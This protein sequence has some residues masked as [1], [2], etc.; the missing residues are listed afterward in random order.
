LAVSVSR[1]HLITRI[2]SFPKKL[3][4]RPYPEKNNFFIVCELSNLTESF[5]FLAT[6]G[7]HAY[8]LLSNWCH[9]ILFKN[10]EEKWPIVKHGMIPFYLH[11]FSSCHQQT[12]FY[13][14]QENCRS[15][16]LNSCA[17]ILAIDTSVTTIETQSFLETTAILDMQLTKRC[18]HPG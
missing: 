16:F 12:W 17:T 14:C 18:S 4:K 15:L 11:Q 9:Y 6:N 13:C 2:I 7:K 3:K 5:Y 10:L 8:S 1:N